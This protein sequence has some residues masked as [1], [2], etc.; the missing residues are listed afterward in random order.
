[1]VVELASS[2]YAAEKQEQI[3]QSQRSYLNALLTLT[4]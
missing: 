1:V 4:L 3:Q 2:G